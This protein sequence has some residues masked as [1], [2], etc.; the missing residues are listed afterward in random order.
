MPPGLSPIAI[1]RDYVLGLFTAEDG[2]RWVQQH[3]LN[4]GERHPPGT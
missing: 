4:R 3:Q 1:G 2:S